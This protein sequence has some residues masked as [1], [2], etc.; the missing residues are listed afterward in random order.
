M[1]TMLQD[2]DGNI[3]SK[4]IAGFISFGVAV[5]LSVVA[6]MWAGNAEIASDLVKMFLTFSAAVLGVSVAERFGK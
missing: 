3:S 5:V 4:R 6:L 2:K 1:N